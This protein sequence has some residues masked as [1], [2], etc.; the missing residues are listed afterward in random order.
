MIQRVIVWGMLAACGAAA[1]PAWS[2]PPI[3]ASARAVEHNNKGAALIDSGDLALAEFELKTAISLSPDY[4]EAYS[5][6]GIVY[7]QR[8]QYEQAID[9]FKKS[10]ELDPSYVSA[11]SHLG[12]VYLAQGKLDAAVDVLR[13]ALKKDPRFDYAAFNLGLAYLLK[14]R[15]TDNA[16]SK[17]ELYDDAEKHFILATQLNPKLS[18]AHA[19]LGDLYAETQRYETAEIRYRLAL[20]DNPTK[21][22]LYNQLAAVQQAQGKAGD[23]AKLRAKAQ[24]MQQAALADRSMKEALALL[25]EV[26]QLRAADKLKE[27][28]VSLSRAD[29]A[30]QA[31]LKA[32]PDRVDALYAAGVVAER[33]GK[34]RAAQ[35][36]WERT[37]K[38]TP[39]HPGAEYNLGLLAMRDGRI[40][41]AVVQWCHFLQHAG[42]AFPEQTAN[43]RRQLQEKQLQCPSSS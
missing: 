16:S 27:S 18:E 26:E 40:S 14:A 28:Q 24:V 2:K 17:A 10:A 7:K 41:E 11:Q 23:A 4:A 6:L 38:L 29:Q 3:Q 39:G 8:K 36:Y 32:A 22:E 37:L 43:V 31:V 5:N 21:M 25:A 12:A 33:Q 35:S 9:Y 34:T 42:P 20:E 1:T 19:N 30:L 13:K 15:E